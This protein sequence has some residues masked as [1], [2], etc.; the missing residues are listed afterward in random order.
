MSPEF[1]LQL[2]IAFGGPIA[3]YGAVKADLARALAKA[4]AAESAAIRAHDR[5]DHFTTKRG[6]P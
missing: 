4:E 3:V 2:V 1:V 5:I 6:T